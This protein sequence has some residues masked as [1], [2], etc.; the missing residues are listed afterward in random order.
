MSTLQ[1][2]DADRAARHHAASAAGTLERTERKRRLMLLNANKAFE[3]ADIWF[4]H[5]GW[6]YITISRVILTKPLY[7]RRSEALFRH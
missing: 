4:A 3:I 5:R 7:R 1:I 2:I 6:L